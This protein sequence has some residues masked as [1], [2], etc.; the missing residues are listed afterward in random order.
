M[1]TEYRV[2]VEQVCPWKSWLVQFRTMSTD[3]EHTQTRKQR[4]L[5][6]EKRPQGTATLLCFQTQ[7]GCVLQTYTDFFVSEQDKLCGAICPI[8]TPVSRFGMA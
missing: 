4:M 5:S 7:A 8:N 2:L 1:Y 6:S 3:R